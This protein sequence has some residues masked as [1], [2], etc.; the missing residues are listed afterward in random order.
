MQ[1]KKSQWRDEMQQRDKMGSQL[2]FTYSTLTI[3]CKYSIVRPPPPFFFFKGGIDLTKNPKKVEG[4][5][6]CER[7][8]GDPKKRGNS[9]GKGGCC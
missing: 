7:V 2:T 5:K 8:S 3:F 9:V 6:N 4:W 1:I